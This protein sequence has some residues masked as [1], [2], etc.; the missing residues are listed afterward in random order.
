MT[1][2]KIGLLPLTVQRIRGLAM[3]SSGK[4]SMAG[5][6]YRENGP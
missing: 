5:S 3:E 2:I 4:Y 1:S 6:K